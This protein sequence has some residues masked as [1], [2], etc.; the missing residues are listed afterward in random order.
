MFFCLYFPTAML[1]EFPG[2][3]LDQ[4]LVDQA[5]VDSILGQVVM[6]TLGRKQTE[7]HILEPSHKNIILA[8]YR[9]GID[10]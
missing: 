6:G 7:S 4:W 1:C 5:A 2:V 9:I 3:L 10:N 8:Y